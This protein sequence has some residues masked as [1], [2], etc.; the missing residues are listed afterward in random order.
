MRPLTIKTSVLLKQAGTCHEPSR[1]PYQAAVVLGA[2]QGLKDAQSLG[3]RVWGL[4]LK[5]QGL[6]LKA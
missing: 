4:G 6:G 1:E 5:V 3:F 2:F